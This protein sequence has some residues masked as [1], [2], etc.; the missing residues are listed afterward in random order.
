MYPQLL[1]RTWGWGLGPELDWGGQ[2]LEPWGGTPQ[3]QNP[4]GRL[5][6][7]PEHSARAEK[8]KIFTREGQDVL[9]RVRGKE[10]TPATVGSRA[11]SR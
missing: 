2:G 11:M 7:L 4:A 1:Q 6:A 3:L 8:G 5:T 9:T 10:A